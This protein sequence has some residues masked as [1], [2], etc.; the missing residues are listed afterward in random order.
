MEKVVCKNGKEEEWEQFQ[1]LFLVGQKARRGIKIS[2]NGM[3]L[4]GDWN[5]DK[6]LPGYWKI[7]YS[8][9]SC[10]SGMS[11]VERGSSIPFPHGIGSIEHSNG[12][13][14]VGNFV[15]GKK[16]GPGVCI[17]ANRDMWDGV[18]LDGAPDRDAGGVLVCSDG[19]TRKFPTPSAK[20]NPIDA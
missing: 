8:D 4:E 18:W 7:T 15:N 6:P 5:V 12:D 10:Y 2:A 14:F 13:Y 11:Q 17:Y 16:K 1:G 19:C 9:G 3:I 20:E